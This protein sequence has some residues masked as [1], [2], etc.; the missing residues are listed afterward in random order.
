M[1]GI[2]I[3]LGIITCLLIGEKFAKDQNLDQEL[4]WGAS[5]WL[6]LSG[7]IGA[8]LFHVIDYFE[9]YS[10]NIIQI[11]LINKG[12]LGIY[13]AILGG[14]LGSLA[15]FKLKGG[16]FGTYINIAA[17]VLPLGQSIGRL[18][19][20]FNLEIFGKPTNL[21]WG[22]YIPYFLRP[23]QY[24]INDV[25]HPLFFYESILNFLSFIVLVLLYRRKGANPKHMSNSLYY[26]LIYSICYG[27]IRFF[28]D[29]LRIDP[30]K[31]GIFNVS[32]TISALLL[33]FGVSGLIVTGAK[34]KIKR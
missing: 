4:Y 14:I 31:I 13:G 26:V 15:Y 24:K 16:N 3:T 12:G 19:N 21:P 7:V 28:L 32:Q 18:G 22:I 33:V 27:S 1:Y 8:R 10:K 29:F 20:F 23:D 17:I 11:L 5:F 2:L 30:W 25:Y 34:F 9:Y 6:I